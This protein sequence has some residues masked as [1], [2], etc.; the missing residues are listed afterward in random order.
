[1]YFEQIFSIIIE[2][3]NNVTKH[4]CLHGK[5]QI[6]GLFPYINVAKMDNTM[7]QLANKIDKFVP[8]LA[9]HTLKFAS[10]YVWPGGNVVCN[11][12]L[13]A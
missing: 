9:I 4:H 12:N 6:F 8:K 2:K 5:Y 1:M 13:P 7:G 10:C 11:Q 3:Q